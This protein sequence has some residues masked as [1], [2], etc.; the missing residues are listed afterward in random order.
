M[1]SNLALDS[2]TEQKG[3]RLLFIL[4]PRFVQSGRPRGRIVLQVQIDLQSSSA[5]LVLQKVFDDSLTDESKPLGSLIMVRPHAPAS[6]SRLPQ[7]RD[8][9]ARYDSNLTKANHLSTL[10]SMI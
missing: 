5:S 6:L 9:P 8:R 3:D 10:P 2:Y 4:P 7:D 1:G